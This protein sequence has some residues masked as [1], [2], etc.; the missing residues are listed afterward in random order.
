MDHSRLPTT[1][2]EPLV[3][4]RSQL[5]DYG[6]EL[7]RAAGIERTVGYAFGEASAGGNVQAKVSHEAQEAGAVLR[8]A[9]GNLAPVS[10]L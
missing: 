7:V 10:G 6:P 4:E 8:G 9:I 5:L 1:R 3:H 2:L